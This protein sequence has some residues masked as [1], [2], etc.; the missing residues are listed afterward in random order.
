MNILKPKITV[1][2]VCRNS[3]NSIASTIMSVLDQNYATIEF[4]LIDGLSTDNTLSIAK[5][6]QEKFNKKDFKF[7]YVSEKDLGIYDAMNKG[8]SKSTGEWII[9]MNSGDIFYDE[10]VLQNCFKENLII[11]YDVIYGDTMALNSKTV[12]RPPGNISKG[13]FINETIC[14][15]SVFCHRRVFEYIGLFDLKYRV[16]ADREWL[17]KAKIA[18]FK[19]K[20]IPTIIS[21]WDEQGFSKDN[22][23][24]YHEEIKILKLKYFSIFEL[25]SS[26][27][28]RKLL[29]I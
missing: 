29:R 21:V 3:E 9:F 19:F 5:S 27:L 7:N 10:F 14:H 25:F 1:I 20:Y 4:L 13:Y 22:L 28:K 12:I 8:V 24:V 6:F 16:I 11:G 18:N 23:S 17:L 2:T 26:R 15:Q